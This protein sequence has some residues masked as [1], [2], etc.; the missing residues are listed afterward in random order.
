MNDEMN[1]GPRLGAV[2]RAVIATGVLWGSLLGGLAYAFWPD[3]DW[4]EAP[5]EVELAW[6]Q[7]PYPVILAP[8]ATAAT[9]QAEFTPALQR[10]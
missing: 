1:R 7:V 8:E 5:A 3:S 6:E 2:A 10:R 4:R 9:N